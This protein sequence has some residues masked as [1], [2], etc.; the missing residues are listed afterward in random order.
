MN[1]LELVGPLGQK[2]MVEFT[3]YPHSLALMREWGARGFTSGT[4]PHGGYQLPYCMADS[5]DWALIGARKWTNH[6]GEDVILHRGHSYKIRHMDAVDSKKMTLPAC[7]KV[8]RGAKPS[9]PEHIREKSDG[10]IEYVTL[11]VFRGNAK[12][13]PDYEAPRQ[14]QQQRPPQQQQA[15]EAEQPAPRNW[16]QEWMEAAGG[17]RYNTKEG[18]DELGSAVAR[19]LNIEGAKNFTDLWNLKRDDVY[20]RLIF[21]AREWIKEDQQQQAS[22]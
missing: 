17:T 22:D 14:G 15:T 13:I 7:V 18:R 9:D 2:I 11:A 19:A 1:Q 20:E 8:S 16:T 10:E 6:E 5:F 3:D 12:T 4:V 21:T